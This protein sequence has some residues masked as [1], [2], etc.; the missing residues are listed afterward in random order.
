MSKLKTETQLPQTIVSGSFLEKNFLKPPIIIY[1]DFD[2]VF[3]KNRWFCK[4]ADDYAY[5]LPKKY[6]EIN[7]EDLT[8]HF[9]YDNSK[10]PKQS[11]IYSFKNKKDAVLVAKEVIKNANFDFK[12]WFL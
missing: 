1:K 11:I 12:I 9:D 6:Q 8:Y 7:F 2:E 10:S 3:E 5:Y 4:V